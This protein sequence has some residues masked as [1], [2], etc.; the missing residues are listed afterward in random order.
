MV[1]LEKHTFPLVE[2]MITSLHLN[3]GHYLGSHEPETQTS[4]CFQATLG[5]HSERNVFEQQS[6]LYAV[7]KKVHNSKTNYLPFHWQL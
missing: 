4:P 7:R 5:G 2:E 3:W 6:V 1:P